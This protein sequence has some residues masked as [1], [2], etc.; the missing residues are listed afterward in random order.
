MSSGTTLLIVED[1][2]ELRSLLQNMFS[3]QFSTVLTAVNGKVAEEILKENTP[4]LVLS[5][6]HMPEKGGIEMVK[7]LRAQGN[8]IPVV[9]MSSSTDRAELLK[10][11]KL[12]VLD[13]VEK[14]FN[15]KD[16]EKAIL[17][18]LQVV[19]RTHSLPDLITMYGAESE[20]VKKMK[21]LIGLFRVINAENK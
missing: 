18:T 4:D 2:N 19:L 20:Q 9:I 3:K 5:D 1:D 8:D 6:L 12:G 14:P 13:Y 10:V 17:R 7:T 11:L 21:K 16:L 15:R